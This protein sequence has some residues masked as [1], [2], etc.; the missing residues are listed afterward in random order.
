MSASAAV[1]VKNPPRL[2]FLP[3]LEKQINSGKYEGVEWLDQ[4]KQVFK[5]PWVHAK[6]HHF[7]LERDAALPRDWAKYK[8]RYKGDDPKEVREWKINFRCAL[9]MSRR[10]VE[11]TNFAAGYPCSKIY[12]ILPRDLTLTRAVLPSKTIPPS[13]PPHPRS[14]G[15]NPTRRVDIYREFRCPSCK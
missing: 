7:C 6:K 12:Q 9:Q 2:S 5:I 15:I 8:D 14:S 10:I 4:D 13:D 11:L 1:A 3:W